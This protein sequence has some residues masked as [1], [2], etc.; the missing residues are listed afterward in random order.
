MKRRITIETSADK[1]LTNLYDRK[2]DTTVSFPNYED[3]W[4]TLFVLL[5]GFFPKSSRLIACNLVRLGWYQRVHR[6]I[7]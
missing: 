4:A 3:A 6:L 5:P 7:P 2:T 1:L